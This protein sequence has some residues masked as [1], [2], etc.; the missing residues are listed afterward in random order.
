MAVSG[1]SNGRQAVIVAAGRSAIGRARKGSL[2]DTRP[3]DLAAEIIAG[4][5]TRVPQ[6][7]PADIDDLYLGAWEHSG[8]QGENLARRVG[9]LLGWDGVPGAT[10]NRGCGSS[11]QTTR[12]AANAICAGDGHV[13]VSAGVESVSRYAAE[14]ATGAGVEAFHNPRFAEAGQRTAE[15]SATATATTWLDPRE[16]G[17]LPDIYISMGQTAENVADL[18][19]VSRRDQDEFAALSQARA[20]R[21]L[22][23]G[24]FAAETIAV[25]L[26]DGRVF[27]ADECPRPGTTPEI[28]AGLP[29]VFRPNG[30]ITA[31][32]S[33][34]LNDGAAAV[35]MM[36]DRMASELD[37]TPLARIVSFGA[38]GL[39]PEIMGLGPVDA[40][41][42]ALDRAG[43]SMGD[44]G[45]VEINEAF[46]AQVLASQRELG[47]DID[48]LNV[49]GGAIA[50]GHPFGMT[51]ARITATLINALQRH[52]AHF[53]LETM[54]IGGG[55]G[56]AMV[57]ERLS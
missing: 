53:G 5:L 36:S 3:D 13:Y 55:Q 18:A 52:D 2:V 49:N 43:L 57:V 56:M 17:E 31:G 10:V 46:A 22:R 28:L 32:N 47:I 20:A 34:P 40:S 44:I 35:V 12:M 4:T 41:R 1:N 6:L 54:C 29:P 25:T 50:L 8:E 33:C 23:T 21:A 19:G 14:T 24:A 27:D 30:S 26:P 37:L 9:V 15:A 7:N 42:Q 51:G 45:L 16:R 38:C 39:S 11:L 48:R